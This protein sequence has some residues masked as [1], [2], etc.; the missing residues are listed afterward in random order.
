MQQQQRQQQPSSSSSSS[1]N[2]LQSSSFTIYDNNHHPQLTQKKSISSSR[3]RLGLRSL[4]PLDDKQNQLFDQIFTCDEQTI[5]ISECIFNQCITRLTTN[6]INT[7]IILSGQYREI[8]QLQNT[9]I[10]LTLN[11]LYCFVNEQNKN[12]SL[13]ISIQEFS[14][15]IT[16]NILTSRGKSLLLTSDYSVTCPIQT[17][18]YIN[19]LCTEHKSFPLL[20]TFYLINISSNNNFVQFHILST[21][22]NDDE[23]TK[24]TN[25]NSQDEFSNLLM[26]L[27][28]SLPSSRQKQSYH[29]SNKRNN[30]E[31]SLFS[32]TSILN[33][34]VINID[35]HFLYILATIKSDKQL[36]YWTKIQRLFKTKRNRL[37]MSRDSSSIDTVIN[38]PNEEIWVDGPLSSSSNH[39]NEIWIDGPREF[40]PRSPKISHLRSTP[41]HRSK[42]MCTKAKYPTILSPKHTLSLY[43]HND[44]D[45]SIS[46]NT[47]ETES[48]ISSHCHLPVL[49]VFKDHLLLPFRSNQTSSSSSNIKPIN[50]N[51]SSKINLKLSTNQLNN[52]LEILEKT[53]ETLLIPS[54]INSNEIERESIMSKSLNRMDQLSLTMSNDEK[55]KRLSRIVSPT[56]FDK[57]LS[58][59]NYHPSVPNSPLIISKNRHSKTSN[60]LLQSIKKPQVPIRTTSLAETNSRPSLFQRLFGLRSLSS[61]PQQSIVIQ[62]PPSSPLISPLT[63]TLDSHDD[64]MPLTTSSTASSTSG[65]TS[66]SGYESMSNTI[67]EEMIASIPSNINNENNS[68]KTRNK[69]IRKDRRLNNNALWNSPIIPD[70]SHHQQRLSELKHRQNELK[71]ELAMTKAFLLM[72]K[73]KNLDHND[74]LN[75]TNSPLHTILSNNYDEEKE[76][77]QDIENLEKRLASAKSQLMFSTYQKTKQF[78]A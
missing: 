54:S 17:F 62:S 45:E 33:E 46:S 39:K 8:Y 61:N 4:Y 20:I 66:S 51:E 63:V 18:Q 32:L 76:L 41:K 28:L 72:D 60:H 16:K 2:H 59:E 24:T 74:F 35:E 13:R 38:H 25:N 7:L 9:L 29:L 69:S 1:V 48:I 27:S 70:K 23:T 56:R 75:S 77:E 42:L 19:H 53:L 37:K 58:S 68:I 49:P 15:E 40:S 34:Y 14:N 44:I 22:D 47:F 31:Q 3:I 57:I 5:D 65:R 26:S 12:L 36:K 30:H 21:N 10:S 67:L 64:L 6:Y 43:A 73:N 52:D 11:H 71:L 78:K 50:I 55:N